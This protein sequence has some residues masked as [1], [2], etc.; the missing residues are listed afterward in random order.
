MPIDHTTATIYGVCNGVNTVTTLRF[1]EDVTT[2]AE[3]QALAVNVRDNWL[4]HFKTGCAAAMVFQSIVIQLM[5][6]ANDSPYV[7]PINVVGGGSTLS[8]QQVAICWRLETGVA[9]RN[10]KGRLYV[11][12][13]HTGAMNAGIIAS[14]TQTSLNAALVTVRGIW[15]A[16]GSSP[17]HLAVLSRVDNVKRAV[18]DIQYNQLFSTL[19]S[20]RLG[21]GI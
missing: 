12:G 9:G 19:R 14:A 11:P 3:K 7:L 17:F 16:G 4:P 13:I 10:G 5:N 21:T 18:V 2:L 1:M 8:T 15:C 20:R 6:N